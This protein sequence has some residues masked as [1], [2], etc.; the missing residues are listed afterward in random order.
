MLRKC[1]TGSA[2]I[3]CICTVWEHSCCRCRR[4][5]EHAFAAH[6]PPCQVTDPYKA[7]YGVENA[8]FAV[9]QLAQVGRVQQGTPALA[10]GRERHR[11]SP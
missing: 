11:V 4:V 6:T 7:S 8:M 5:R 10:A 2:G 3:P 9:T 1:F